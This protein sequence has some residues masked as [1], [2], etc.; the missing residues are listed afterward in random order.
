MLN[1]SI[2][3]EKAAWLIERSMVKGAD[4]AAVYT[5]WQDAHE[6]IIRMGEVEE[7]SQSESVS[8]ELIATKNYCRAGVTMCDLSE[9]SLEEMV[10]KVMALCQYT[11]R[12]P[13]YSLPDKEFLATQITDLELADPQMLALHT[14]DRIQLAKDLEHSFLASD[15]R[16]QSFGASATSEFCYAGLANSYG[17]NEVEVRSL[18]TLQMGGYALDPD[19]PAIPNADSSWRQSD[20]VS[21]A[22]RFLEDLKPTQAIASDAARKV[23]GKLGAKKPKSGKFRT[24]F[25]PRPIRILLQAIFDALKG[26]NIY[27]KRS[28]LGGKLGTQVAVPQLSIYDRPRI[29]RGLGSR[30][31][32]DEGVAS[33]SCALIDGGSLN[34]YLLSSYSAKKLGMEPTGHTGGVSNI[35]VEPGVYHEAALLNALGK[36]IW[37]TD[38]LGENF[39][40]SSG[41]FSI[42]ASG[43]WV[44]GGEVVHPLQEFTIS[45]NLGD[46]LKKI[47]HIGANIDV[48]HEIRTPGMIVEEM[49][50]AG[51]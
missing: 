13:Y 40:L 11:G 32:D 47:T 35:H 43:F 34:T 42:G 38:L 39:D 33:K 3:K 44:E 17:F 22:T 37:I 20:G 24:Y 8:I 14:A 1:T 15:P 19:N 18:V 23:L 12:D 28:F 45:G 4:M 26:H 46:W 41:D 29:K 10:E 25:D 50:I 31:F 48:F 6:V 5:H 21:I 7:I 27:L 30:C 49:T 2:L 51:T 36:G 9:A 16:L